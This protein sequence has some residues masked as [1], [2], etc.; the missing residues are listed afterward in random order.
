M[1]ALFCLNKEQYFAHENILAICQFLQNK[2]G[3]EF[4]SS[5][6]SRL[7]NIEWF[8]TPCS[9]IQDSNFVEYYVKRNPLDVKPII[10]GNEVVVKLHEKLSGNFFINVECQNANAI[11]LNEP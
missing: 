2:T 4:N 9:D 5:Q 3:I 11:I 1:E 10:S 8:E 6:F 7:G